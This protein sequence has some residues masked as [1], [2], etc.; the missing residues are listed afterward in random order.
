MGEIQVQRERCQRDISGKTGI[1]DHGW[2]D[3]CGRDVVWKTVV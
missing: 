2:G 1:G 3:R